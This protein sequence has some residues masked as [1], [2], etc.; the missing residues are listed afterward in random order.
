MT[1]YKWASYQSATGCTKYGP[2]GCQALL[3]YL[4][5]RFPGQVSMG[6]CNCRTVRGGSSYSHHA[7]CRAYDEGF[8]VFVGQTIGIETLELVGPHG[9]EI[10]CDHMIMNQNPGSSGRG[11][12]RIYSAR[13]PQGRVYTGS[14]AHKNHNHIGLT[15]NAGRNL[16]YATLVSVLGPAIPGGDDNDMLL[17]KSSEGQNVAEVQK[18]MAEKFNQN[19]GTWTPWPGKSAFDGQA[20]AKGEDGDFG[21][22]CETNVKN[23]QGSLGQA[24]TGIVD[25]LFWDALVHH[26]YGGGGGGDHPDKDHASLATKAQVEAER[27]KIDKHV[28]D[29]KTSTPHS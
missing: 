29:A 28:A 27:V 10:G 16:T 23:V 8:A 19:N 6:I 2:A 26:R 25:Q 13:S 12:P 1:N 7:E 21:G 3:T 15:R 9:A 11:D 18:I 17:Q 5:D 4:E 24:K 22:T 20:F 14:H